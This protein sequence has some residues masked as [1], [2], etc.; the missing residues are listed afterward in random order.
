MPINPLK[1]FKSLA[2]RISR[3]FYHMGIRTPYK[4][5]FAYEW[6]VFGIVLQLFWPNHNRFTAPLHE[7]WTFEVWYDNQWRHGTVFSKNYWKIRFMKWSGQ[8]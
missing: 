7:K 3:I 4:G 2:F 1:V 8:W 5:S 6:E